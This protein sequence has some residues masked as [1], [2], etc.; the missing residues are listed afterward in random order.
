[1]AV[2]RS[3]LSDD[4]GCFVFAL[5]PPGTYRVTVVKIGYSQAALASVEISVTESIRLSIPMKLAGLAQCIEVHGNASDLQSDSVAL[6]RVVDAHMLEI[7][8]LCSGNPQNGPI[9]ANA[10]G[11]P[12]GVISSV[13]SNPRVGQLAVK[14]I[15]LSGSYEENAGCV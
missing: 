3:T 7:H 4:E 10:L 12:I 11:K 15:F 13:S 6:G 14:L 8:R 9:F 5:L 2:S 1:M